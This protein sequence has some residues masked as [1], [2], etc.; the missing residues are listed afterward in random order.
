[1]NAAESA[2]LLEAQLQPYRG[3]THT[4]LCSL[5]RAPVATQLAGPSGARYQLLIQAAWVDRPGGA[6]RIV[7]GIDDSG[8]QRFQPLTASFVVAATPAGAAAA[9]V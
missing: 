7:G 1:M 6:L 4:Q 2:A 9:P 8:W 5:L 3:Q